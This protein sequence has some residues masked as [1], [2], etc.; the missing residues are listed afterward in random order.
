MLLHRK[1]F[2]S[3]LIVLAIASPGYCTWYQ[4]DMFSRRTERLGEKDSVLPYWSKEFEVWTQD[5]TCFGKA[6][7]H[8]I[9]N[10]ESVTYTAVAPTGLYFAL[11]LHFPPGVGEVEVRAKANISS[12]AQSKGPGIGKGTAV[13]F[14]RAEYWLDGLWE[15]AEGSVSKGAANTLIEG[16]PRILVGVS[17]GAP[18][19]FGA[20]TGL[21]IQLQWFNGSGKVTDSAFDYI[22][23]SKCPVTKFRVRE[24]A[25][26]QIYVWARGTNP[27]NRG[28]GMCEVFGEA[29]VKYDLLTH[30]QC[31]TR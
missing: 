11:W 24:S 2:L 25:Q 6:A 30:P 29:T 19:A 5:G 15:K 22:A 1:I 17:L 9:S 13:G 20:T 8:A 23:N 18:G 26:S 28:R 31:P 12:E 10:S 4:V 16:L 3:V 14:C 21:E 27:G 7:A